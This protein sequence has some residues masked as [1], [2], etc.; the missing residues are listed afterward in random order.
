MTKKIGIITI[1]KVNNY[2]AELQAY[3][4]QQ[5]LNSL[6][7]D[8]EVIDYLFYKHPDH[9][10]ESISRP[11]YPYPFKNK[12]LESGL[13]LRDRLTR[14]LASPSQKRRQKNFDDFHIANTHLSRT[15]HSL[16]ELQN[17][18]PRYD[19]YCVG[20]DQVWNPRCFTNLAPYLLSFAPDNARKISYASSFG[21]SSLPSSAESQYAKLL[22]R[23]DS[24]AVRE[25]TGADIVKKLIGKNAQTVLDP[26]LLLSPDDWAKVEKPVPNIP[27]RYLLTY[28][29]RPQLAL[30]NLAQEVAHRH[31]LKIVRLGCRQKFYT[32]P[33]INITDAG[34]AEFLYLF[35]NAAFV[36]TN[37][38]HG[39]AF[40]VNFSKPFFSVLERG[41]N[42]NSR[43][44]SLLGSCGLES[45]VYYDGDPIPSSFDV[46]FSSATRRL[47]SLRNSSIEYL[48]SAING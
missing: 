34:P 46:D 25:S 7:Y 8:A 6:G 16:S 5:C 27:D 1:L 43:Q 42:N 11:F 12:I 33:L 24:I 20:S 30:A 28:E 9:I 38:F 15:F 37:S 31:G 17:E 22:R 36:V 10:R 13:F 26:T 23:F 41:R 40:S 4:L 14:L 32:D 18:C 44:L 39:T 48:N 3:A 2:G 45:Q 19:V 47:A 35:R 21:V 29:L